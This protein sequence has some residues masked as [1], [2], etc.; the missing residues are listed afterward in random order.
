MRKTLAA[1]AT[2]AAL[3]AAAATPASAAATLPGGCVYAE[4]INP[5]SV[6][7]PFYASDGNARVDTYS[8]LCIYSLVRYGKWKYT[9]YNRVLIDEHGSHVQLRFR[10]I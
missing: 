10:H 5:F 2:A 3:S 4:K 8:K 7:G 6:S 9:G 1:L